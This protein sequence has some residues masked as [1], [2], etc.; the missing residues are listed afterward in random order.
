MSY[1]IELVFFTEQPIRRVRRGKAEEKTPN[2]L[3]YRAALRRSLPAVRAGKANV[4]IRK[5]GDDD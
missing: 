5:V 4:S 1:V 2:F 3:Q